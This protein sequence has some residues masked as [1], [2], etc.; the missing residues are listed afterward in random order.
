MQATAKAKFDETVDLRLVL[1]TD[2]RRGDQAVRGTASLPH[3][4]GRSVRV[5][6]FADPDDAAG[7]KAAGARLGAASC[8]APTC[9]LLLC[10]NFHRFVLDGGASLSGQI[11]EHPRGFKRRV[12]QKV[13]HTCRHLLHPDIAGADII[14]DEAL[15]NR[16][17]KDGSSAIEF[18][19]LVATK[20]SKPL[21]SRVARIL[22]PKGLMPNPKLGTLTDDVAAAV[23]TFKAGRIDFR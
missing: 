10:V 11:R 18:D 5:A 6:V 1:G 15:I 16:I 14:G 17:A 4:T 23:R 22:G 19:K 2:P 8:T 13:N 7:A 20:S 3:G 12:W 9:S 21:L